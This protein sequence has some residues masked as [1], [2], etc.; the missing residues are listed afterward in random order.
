MYDE[1]LCEAE[2]N[3]VEVREHS[4][5]CLRLKGLYT[6]N[7]ITLNPTAIGSS[8]EKTCVL[9]EE[10]GHF[11]TSF[12]NIL[13]QSDIRNRKQELR[14]RSWAYER[15]VS[16]PAIVQAHQLGI[17]NRFELAEHL[18]VTEEFLGAALKRFQEK[19]GLCVPVGKYTVCFDPLGVIEYFD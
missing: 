2:K 8:V 12:G 19:Y 4:F 5:K 17:R 11:H 15:V 10:L 14:A 16:L 9:A 6:D 3:G 13:N 18:G 7:V 1:L